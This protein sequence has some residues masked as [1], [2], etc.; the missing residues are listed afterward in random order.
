M[1]ADCSS[2]VG[3]AKSSWREG[4]GDAA[5]LGEH[6][7]P[8]GLGGMC[9]E[10]GHDEQSPHQRLHLV[11]GDAFLAHEPD[12]RGN[13]FA[14]GL[15]PGLGFVRAAPQDADPLL[16]LGE[17]HELEVGG[18]GLDHAPRLDERQR[19]DPLEQAQAGL[20]VARAMRLG[21]GPDLLDP[22]EE[23]PALLL[24]QGLAQQVAEP[25]D[26][27]RKGVCHGAGMGR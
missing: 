20:G 9:G 8:L 23:G 1:R 5:E 26:L 3:E 27:L 10:D 13:G 19:L 14:H 21:Q 24:D 7:P 25:V 11:G 18:E 4:V 15:A 17:V 16:F 22:V 6:G 12:G 2:G